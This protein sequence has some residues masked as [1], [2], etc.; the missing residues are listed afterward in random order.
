MVV[1]G[2]DVPGEGYFLGGDVEGDGGG[3]DEV[4]VAAVDGTEGAV[5]F[6][7]EPSHLVHAAAVAFDVFAVA[8]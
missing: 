6:G 4:V 3:V 2:G 8:D 1:G 7:F 5:G